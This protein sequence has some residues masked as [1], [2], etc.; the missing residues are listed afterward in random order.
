MIQNG[1]KD[2]VFVATDLNLVISIHSLI[3]SINAG[4]VEFI[5]CNKRTCDLIESIRSDEINGRIVDSMSLERRDQPILY[6]FLA[7]K[8]RI[9]D[10]NHRLLRRK[11]D[12]TSSTEIIDISSS[13]LQRYS[14]P[15]SSLPKR[16]QK[17]WASIVFGEG[18]V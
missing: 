15:L 14:E 17:R 13:V 9:V 3:Q 2:E 1:H 4:K 12:G 5:R 11:Q 7:G 18:N 10:G 6:A 16:D 8:G